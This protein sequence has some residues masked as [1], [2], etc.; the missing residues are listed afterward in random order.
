MKMV[1]AATKGAGRRPGG[2]H[3]P[4]VTG[5]GTAARQCRAVTLLEIILA[6]GLLVVLSSMTYWFYSSMLQTRE[7]GTAEAHRFR[8]VRAVMD[9]LGREIR[10]AVVITVDGQVG[11]RGETDRLWIVT[12]RVPTR[13]LSRK[14]G[15]REAA[16]M[17]EYD[18]KRVEYS[19][20]RHPEILHEREGWELPLGLARSE[21]LIP[22]PTSVAAVEELS[23]EAAPLEGEEQEPLEGLEEQLLDQMRS[24][25]RKQGG[26]GI[27]RDADIRWQELYAPE[28]RYLRLCYYDGNQWWDTW[29]VKGESPLPQMVLVTVGFEPRPPLEDFQGQ[30]KENEEFCTCL[31]R[32]PPDCEPLAPHEYSEVIRVAQ[33]DPLFRSR[34]TRETQAVIEQAQRQQDEEAEEER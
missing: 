33:A 31:N 1:K 5:C 22:R 27:G 14:R 9:Q 15:S 34:V 21:T 11:L 2:W 7:T 32:D 24:E 4:L 23:E 25:E 18:L 8:L 30:D 13:D 19:I 26:G 16:P 28:I 12:S 29:D 3:S 20:A 17:P 6:I 10:Q